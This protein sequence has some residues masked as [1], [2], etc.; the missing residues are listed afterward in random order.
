MGFIQSEEIV[1]LIQDIR[2][3]NKRVGFYKTVPVGN[4]NR[5]QLYD[6]QNKLKGWFDSASNT[7]V[8]SNGQFYGQGNIVG[9]LLHT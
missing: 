8:T 9:T 3:N 1:M 5:V 4:G 6:A 2:I 7:T